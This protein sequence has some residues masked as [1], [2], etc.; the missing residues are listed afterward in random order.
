VS[1]I[2]DETLGTNEIINNSIL[3]DKDMPRQNN[4]T[5]EPNDSDKR[6]HLISKLGTIV[7]SVPELVDVVDQIMNLTETTLRASAS[8]VLLLDQAKE[9]FTFRFANGP[10]E[11]MLKHVT[12]NTRSGIAGWVACNGKPLIVNDVTKDPRFCMDID[13]VTGFNTRSVMCAPLLSHGKVI[14]VIEVLNKLDG[15]AF[16]EKDLEVLVAVASIAAMAIDLTQADQ[17]KRKMDEQL[18]IAGR[19][20]AVGELTAGITHEL[21]N[22]LS[23]IQ[24][25]AQFLLQRENLDEEIKIDM[26]TIYE[27]AQR[28]TKIIS[29]LQ[30]IA[31]RHQPEKRKISINA[32]IRKTLEIQACNLKVN[33]I[34][35][36]LQQAPENLCVLVD[37]DLMRQVFINII[38]NAVQAMTEA[39]GRGIL[40]VEAKSVGDAVQITFTDS[41]P[42]ISEENLSR[43]FDP[44][45]TTKDVGKGTGLGLTICFG[46]IHDHDGCMYARNNKG[47]GA[48]L[49]VELPI[50]YTDQAEATSTNMLRDQ[51]WQHL[52]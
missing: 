21:S 23:A 5:P 51:S 35:L 33:N 49:V 40:I 22:P 8:S 10:A 28:A 43:I 9:K 48:T 44:F 42:G 6:M 36:D 7:C 31:Y 25:F 45:F 39:Y 26:Q 37:P 17:Q 16:E 50:A 47:G 14:G 34:E 30:S 13:K 20:A 1:I 32:L 19:L 3:P 27:G 11:T 15:D 38:N 29:N 12:L 41:G 4:S 46:I 18:Q 2:L 24:G 52:E